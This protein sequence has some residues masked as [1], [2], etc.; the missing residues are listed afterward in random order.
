MSFPTE[1]R[2]AAAIS[3]ALACLLFCVPQ[4]D[5][6]V[7]K[8]KGRSASAAGKVE[9][10]GG[11]RAYQSR[12]TVNGVGGDLTVFGFDVSMQEVAARMK[13]TFGTNFLQ[14]TGDQLATAAIADGNHPIHLLVSQMDSSRT[15]VFFM[16]LDQAPDPS[17]D[18]PWA[19]SALPLIP[20]GSTV[21]SFENADTRTRL[22]IA[23]T[24]D[25]AA[26]AKAYCDDHLRSK[27][28]EPLGSADT[29][30][31]IY[32]RKQDLCIVM[33]HP[34]SGPGGDTRIAVMEKRL[35]A[36]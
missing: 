29:S 6:R 1:S 30:L 4:A 16:R 36:P 2:T 12:V 3:F 5:S 21:F 34:A 26:A 11:T 7:F 23:K 25:T 13:N 31:V 9:A 18:A 8:S 14:Q 15:I 20:G 32:A 22:S 27:G 28:W 10:I 24:S 17:S 35:E 33:V 19:V